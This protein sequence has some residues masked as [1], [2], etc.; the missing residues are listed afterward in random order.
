M[1]PKVSVIITTFND[2]KFIAE[3]IDS[4]LNQTFKDL[5]VVIINDCSTDNTWNIIKS[6]QEK[7]DRIIL[8]ENKENLWPAW[9][10][11]QWLK[12]A[13]WKYIAILDADDI[14]LPERLQIQ[15]DY[16]E[17]NKKIFLVWT[18]AEIIDE[19]WKHINNANIL[20]DLKKIKKR[21]PNKNCFY[22][23]TIMFRNEWFYY[24]D[25]F[26]YAQDYD[27]YLCLLSNWKDL[28]NIPNKLIKYRINS[29]SI[30]VLKSSKQSL[31]AE[32]AIEFYYERLKNWKDNYNEFDKND[33]LNIDIES[34]TNET[35]IKAE[36]VSNF[37]QNNFII[38]KIFCKK[39]FKNYWY[40][41]KYLIYYIL[42]FTNKWFVNFLKKIKS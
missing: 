29:N 4:I 22:H 14:A 28:I 6:Y 3:S 25:K 40:I 17:N 11:N 12:R 36:I 35:V 32:K 8:I 27:F 39:Y 24:R 10:R 31:F 21:L 18:W 37:L 26:R 15:Y 23:P 33:I 1:N 20:C 38:T 19:Y 30:S 42:T 16:L 13:K 2:E 34:T 9:W 5:E 41:N 7:D